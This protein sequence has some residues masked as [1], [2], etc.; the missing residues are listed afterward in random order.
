MLAGVGCEVVVD[1][2]MDRGCSGEGVMTFI[3]QR[4]GDRHY[5]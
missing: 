1:R 5:M 4:R 3:K 2:E